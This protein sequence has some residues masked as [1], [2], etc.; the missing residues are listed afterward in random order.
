MS[1]AFIGEQRAWHCVRRMCELL[2]VSP[3]GHYE[4]RGDRKAFGLPQTKRFVN[5]SLKRMLKVAARM[6]VADQ[7]LEQSFIRIA[8]AR[9]RVKIFEI[10]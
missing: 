5:R 7:R 1:Y 9:M 2:E 4:W 8:E 3:A 10:S 6:D